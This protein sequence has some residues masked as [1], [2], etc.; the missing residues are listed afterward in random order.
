MTYENTLPCVWRSKVWLTYSLGGNANGEVVFKHP[1][2]Y[3]F[4]NGRVN[5]S[6]SMEF[7]GLSVVLF[8]ELFV[9]SFKMELYRYNVH[10]KT[11]RV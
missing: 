10:C 4:Q 11:L 7:K 5:Q 6:I 1:L 2:T 8:C 9:G 3:Y